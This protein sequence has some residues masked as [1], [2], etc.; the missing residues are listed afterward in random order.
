MESHDAEFT[1][2]ENRVPP[3]ASPS[4]PL[5]AEVILTHLQETAGFARAHLSQLENGIANLKQSL[6]LR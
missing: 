2:S 5:H 4:V 1:G 6:G 3:Y